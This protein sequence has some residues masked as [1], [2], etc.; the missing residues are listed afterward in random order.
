MHKEIVDLLLTLESERKI[1]RDQQ[2]MID[3]LQEGIHNDQT[4]LKHGISKKVEAELDFLRQ[5][6][7]TIN[8]ELDAKDLII[9]EL[10][11]KSK[12]R[13]HKKSTIS[14]EFEE[15]NS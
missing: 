11:R 1:I 7:I 8:K 2:S 9:E 14:I 6:I 4:R 5:E 10:R 3:S 15:P 12:E 13:E